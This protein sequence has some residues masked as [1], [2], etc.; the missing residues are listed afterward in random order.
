MRNSATEGFIFEG[1][2]VIRFLRRPSS[3]R[4][5]N[6]LGLAY[7]NQSVDVLQGKSRFLFC[8]LHKAYNYTERAECKLREC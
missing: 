5:I 6:T 4:A 7:K 3:Y 8:D 1:R 2:N